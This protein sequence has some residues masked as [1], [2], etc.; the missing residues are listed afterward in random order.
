[1]PSPVLHIIAGPNGAGKTTLYERMLEHQN[2]PFVNSDLIAAQRWPHEVQERAYDAAQ[3]AQRQRDVLIQSEISFATETVF[4]HE[5]KVDLVR[6][7]L[8]TDYVITLH[9]VIVP[10]D[11]AV[12]RVADRVL[13]GGHDVPEGKIRERHRRLWAHIGE[14]VLLAAEAHV[15]DNSSPENPFRPVAHFKNGQASGVPHWPAWAPADLVRL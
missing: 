3:L 15:Y 13:D 11:L 4:S 9:V 10:E 2:V 5:S 6:H 14:A 8:A 12:Q 7:A 1:M